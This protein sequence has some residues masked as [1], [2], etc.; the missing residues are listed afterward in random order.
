MSQTKEARNKALTLE[1]FD[2]LFNK[3][4][5]NTARHF[6]ST[7]Y[8]YASFRVGTIAPTTWMSTTIFVAFSGEFR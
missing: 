5:A 3:R 2:T 6:V 4:L 1:A 8:A 7:E